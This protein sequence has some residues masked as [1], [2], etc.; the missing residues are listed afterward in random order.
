VKKFPE[1]FG[2]KITR[3]ETNNDLVRR[4]LVISDPVISAM[5]CLP[6]AKKRSLTHEGLQLLDSPSTSAPS[7]ETESSGEEEIDVL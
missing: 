5:R 6:N 3:E 4:L 2:R 7:M 1:S